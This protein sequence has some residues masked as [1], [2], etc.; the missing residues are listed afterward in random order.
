VKVGLVALV[1]LVGLVVPVLRSGATGNDPVRSLYVAAIACTPTDTC[2]AVG[3]RTPAQIA[4]SVRG[5]P[6]TVTTT[7]I[8]FDR[9]YVLS[10]ACSRDGCLLA[11]TSGG[12]V[13]TWLFDSRTHRV[14]ASTWRLAG[15]GTSSV[16]C[17]ASGNCALLSYT[18]GTR[19]IG[20]L[21]R[22]RDG[23]Q[24]W[25]AQRPIISK[26]GWD[27]TMSI[28]NM[29]CV[30]AA[31]CLAV[32][33]SGGTQMG[34]GVA[35]TADGGGHWHAGVNDGLLP[36]DAI[37]CSLRAECFAVGFLDAA[38]PHRLAGTNDDGRVWHRIAASAAA[39]TGGIACTVSGWCTTGS[40]APEGHPW[41]E[42]SPTRALFDADA[43]D[44]AVVG[45]GTH[46]CAA[47]VARELIV[48]RAPGL[49][50]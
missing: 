30:E 41:F 1:M 46:W 12:H 5:G 9:A 14:R 50:I 42:A 32:G 24:H 26:N 39:D 45:G 8:R 18:Y 34:L 20:Y 38:P 21:A 15:T 25:I 17:L 2:L 33:G 6:W 13:A 29:A 47:A 43:M 44:P 10:I 36:A 4:W 48:F 40:S 27:W 37:A 28:T 35:R 16:S 7:A 22:S 23:G 31:S 3:A 11:G 19:T 49:P